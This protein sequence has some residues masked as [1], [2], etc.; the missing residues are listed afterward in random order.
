MSILSLRRKQRE[1]GKIKKEMIMDFEKIFQIRDEFIKKIADIDLYGYQ[2]EFSDNVL[3]S[4]FSNK[5]DTVTAM[6]CRQSGKTEAVCCSVFFLICFYYYIMSKYNRPSPRFY[7][8]GIFAP[9]VQQSQTDFEK[10]KDYLRL[11][12]KNSGFDLKIETANG[13]TIKVLSESHPPITIYCF[14]LSPTSHPESKTLHLIIYEE[15]QDLL[16]FRID[17]TAAPM[18]AS[19]NATEVFIG[20]AGYTRCRFW[21]H[22]NKEHIQKVIVPDTRALEEREKKF[23][24]TKDSFHLNYDYHIQKKIRELGENSDE[25]KTQYRLVWILERGQFIKFEDIIKLEDEYDI[26]FI[27]RF[28][29]CFVGVDWGKANDSTVVTVVDESGRIVEWLEMQ[30]DDYYNQYEYIV[31]LIERKYPGTVGVF[32]DATG[33]QDQSV[34]TLRAMFNQKGLKANVE[35][36]KF[37]AQSKDQMYKNLARLMF[38]KVVD[39][40]VISPAFLKIPKKDS[41]EKERFIK[42]MIDLQK[43]IKGE[44][45]RCH[46]PDG[47]VYHDDYCDSV[48]LACLGF[49][50][51]YVEYEPLLG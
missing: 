9:Q 12:N 15:S 19:T 37:T 26:N 3:R 27:D 11:L 8:I 48:A 5:G 50:H 7:N 2:K 14:T 36:V 40:M 13:N 10:I 43:E 4:V 49:T 30:G 32:C 6:F 41:I 17:K 46:H 22:L 29:T 23:Q 45:W 34:D 31:T 51:N 25:F 33:S 28:G 35:G 47:S 21:E 39:G 42:Q 1:N 24:E 38:D 16:D 20:T 18:G 44:L